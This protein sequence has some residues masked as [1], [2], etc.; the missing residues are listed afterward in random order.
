VFDIV[1]AHAKSNN[2]GNIGIMLIGNFEVEK[3]TK[4]Q[5]ASLK[6]LLKYLQVKYPT[7]KLPSCLY[8]HK[9]FNYTDCPGTNLYPIVLDIKNGKIP[10]Y[11]QGV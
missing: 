2:T 6:E 8:G 9:D 10:I 7:L 4:E 1:G 5:I 3:P 11:E